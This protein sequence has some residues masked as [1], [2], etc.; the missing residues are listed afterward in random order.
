MSTCSTSKGE[1]YLPNKEPASPRK[2]NREGAFRA[3]GEKWSQKAQGGPVLKGIHLT[4]GGGRGLLEP[5]ARTKTLP[6]RG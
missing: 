2:S 5:S 6:R 3:S 4:I 1:L